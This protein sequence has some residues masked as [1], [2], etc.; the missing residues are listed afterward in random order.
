MKRFAKGRFLERFPVWYKRTIF[1][2]HL[3]KFL[4]KKESQCW[5]IKRVV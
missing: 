4:K 2:G 5:L 1:D 3:Q